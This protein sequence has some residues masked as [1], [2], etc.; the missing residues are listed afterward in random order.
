M[1]DLKLI[2]INN[3]QSAE[4]STGHDTC[5]PPSGAQGIPLK[6]NIGSQ[7]QLDIKSLEKSYDCV[8][9]SVDTPVGPVPQVSTMWS[10]SDRWGEIRSRTSA[11]RMKYS[12]PPGLYAVGSPDTDSDVFVSANYKLSFDKLR[13]SLEAMNGW[14]LVLDTKSINVWCAAGKGAFGTEELIERIS[15]TQLEKVV[16]HRRLIVPQLGAV[17]INATSVQKRTRF[18]VLFGPVEARDIPAFINAGYRASRDMRTITF[19]MVDRMILTPMEINPSMK[20]YPLFA[21]IVLLIFGIQPAGILF[22]DAFAG[23][24]PFLILG[25]M[26]IVAGAF[27]TPTLLPFVPFRSFAIKGWIVGMISVFLTVNYFEL[28]TIN[29]I[30][31]RVVTYMFFPLM[32]SYI[33]LQF[34]GSTTYT[35]MSG[36][37]KELKIAIP[38]YLSATIVALLFTIVY[39][40]DLWGVV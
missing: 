26:S 5:C 37:K 36:V 2:N 9:G 35:G 7:K 20:K 32:A 16:Q 12:I 24:L 3:K 28:I 13:Q 30:Y 18:K 1:K 19:S 38:V 8:T 29:S 39:K 27:L 31:L 17:G 23:G 33:A 14:I 25:L 6:L 15:I 4:T 40:L 21:F 11:Y 22:R 10:F 34:T